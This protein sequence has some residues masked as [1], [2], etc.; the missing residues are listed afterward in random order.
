MEIDPNLKEGDILSTYDLQ[1]NAQKQL[2]YKKSHSLKYIETGKT[3]DPEIL[4]LSPN[5]EQNNKKFSK[6]KNKITKDNSLVNPYCSN[7]SKKE[8]KERFHVELEVGNNGPYNFRM[9]K[10]QNYASETPKM[11]EIN[12]ED[13]IT[14]KD[15]NKEPP[16]IK[17]RPTSKDDNREQPMTPMI[18]VKPVYLKI[19]QQ[20]TPPYHPMF[21]SMESLKKAYA[22]KVKFSCIILYLTKIYRMEQHLQEQN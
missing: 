9:R 2:K 4:R 11:Q 21:T 5:G 14:S 16:K 10:P 6:D 13:K 12:I 15:D 8:L 3:N 20:M 1:R 18:K 17:T 22:I 7:W 19:N